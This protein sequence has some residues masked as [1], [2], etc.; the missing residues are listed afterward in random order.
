MKILL[1]EDEAIVIKDLEM[2]LREMG[3]PSIMAFNKGDDF[4]QYTQT[5]GY[6][7]NMKQ[8]IRRKKYRRARMI[9]L[10]STP[11]HHGPERYILYTDRHRI[12]HDTSRV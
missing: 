8:W 9:H 7:P 6:A 11:T 1:L 4:I 2:S 12:H 5:I 10:E 3:Y